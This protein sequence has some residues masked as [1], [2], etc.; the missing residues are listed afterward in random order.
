[1]GPATPGIVLPTPPLFSVLQR[2]C[3]ADMLKAALMSN[4]AYLYL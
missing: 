1:M 4:L 3:R 2:S